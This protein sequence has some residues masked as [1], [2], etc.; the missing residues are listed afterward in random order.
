MR[1]IASS[2]KYNLRVDELPFSKLSIERALHAFRQLNSRLNT[3]KCK[4]VLN[5]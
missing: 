4:S 1:S 2:C 3:Q 5:L